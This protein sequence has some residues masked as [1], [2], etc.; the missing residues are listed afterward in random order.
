MCRSCVCWEFYSLERLKVE[1]GGCECAIESV[2]FG[3]TRCSDVH[4][5]FCL[6]CHAGAS[7]DNNHKFQS[8]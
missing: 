6:T 2:I 1:I 3:C 7:G 5:D 8:F 4:K